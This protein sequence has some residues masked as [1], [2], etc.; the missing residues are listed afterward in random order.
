MYI[1]DKYKFLEEAEKLGM[2]TI[3]FINPDETRIK[4]RELGVDI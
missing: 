1:D 2:A 4:L 3:Q